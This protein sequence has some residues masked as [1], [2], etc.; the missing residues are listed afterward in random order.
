MPFPWVCIL[1]KKGYYCRALTSHILMLL[2]NCLISYSIRPVTSGF[3]CL[4]FPFCLS[5]CALPN[6]SYA[7]R[8]CPLCSAVCCVFR[9]VVCCA[10]LCCSVLSCAVMCC[11][12]PASFLTYPLGRY[13]LTVRTR[14][15]GT[16]LPTKRTPPATLPFFLMMALS[17]SQSDSLVCVCLPSSVRGR[18]SDRCSRLQSSPLHRSSKSSRM[19]LC[20]AGGLEDAGISEVKY[21]ERPTNLGTH[22]MGRLEQKPPAFPTVRLPVPSGSG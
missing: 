11:V 16:Y 1:L 7:P 6:L 15:V 8:V 2:A 17:P 22:H 14:C 5:G 21:T 4:F 9:R 18:C 13:V 12:S 20:F 19:W 10:V 3:L